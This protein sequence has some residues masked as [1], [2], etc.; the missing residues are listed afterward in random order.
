MAVPDP[1]LSGRAEAGVPAGTADVKRPSKGRSAAV[2]VCLVLAALLTTPA[3]IAYWG[4]RTLNDTTRYVNTVG[5]LVNSPEVQDAIATKVTDTIQ[6]QVDIEALLN[7]VFSGVITDRPRLQRLVGPLSGAINSL[8]ERQV[9]EFIASD[10][11]ADLWTAANTR[12]QQTLQR[13]LKGDQTGA[14]SLQ[15]E[16]IVLDVSQV[17]DQVK[18]RL[19]D[20]GL[21]IVQNVPIP[22]V[23][24]QIVLM[25]APQVKQL[26]T[27]YAFANPVA[28]WLI[29][30]VAGLY[31]LAL[32]LSRRRPRTTVIIGVL[33]AANALLIALALTVGRQ[34]FID[35]LSGTT[36]STAAAVF[37][38][39][40]LSYL[41]RGRQVFFRL[42][43]V[44]VVIG[45]FAGPNKSGTAVRTAVRDGLEGIGAAL[46]N[47]PVGTAG[48][49]VAANARWLRVVIGLLGAVV[50]FW[51]N[52]VSQGRLFWSLALVALL[53]VVVQLLVGAGRASAA[54][55]PV[56]PAEAVAGTA[57]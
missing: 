6:D 53:L 14:V 12:A 25:E 51:G 56:P 49:W 10:A 11:F 1:T 38:D 19:V 31:L 50:L 52:N 30:V 22:D 7:D 33:M 47:G 39:Q 45:W 9:R 2:I 3:A 40:L 5:P 35:A 32:L 37:Y 15:G 55:R 21:T 28:Q 44:I 46:S 23:D 24:K 57:N 34:L 36:F 48:R 26:R 41:E 43:L 17:I 16:Q 54:S 42:G 20:R 18:Q 27:I 4:Q 13:V 29:V 8:I